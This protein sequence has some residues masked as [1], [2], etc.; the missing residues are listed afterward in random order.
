[1]PSSQPAGGGEGG[2]VHAHTSAGLEGAAAAASLLARASP[3][4]GYSVVCLAAPTVAH[5]NPCLAPTSNNLPHTDT[6]AERLLPRVFCAPEF[7]ARLGDNACAMY[8]DVIPFLGQNP[9][10]GLARA[11]GVAHSCGRFRELPV[12]SQT[13]KWEYQ[14]AFTVFYTSSGLLTARF[15][16]AT[17]A[18]QTQ[19][20]VLLAD[21]LS[22]ARQ[23]WQPAMYTYGGARACMRALSCSVSFSPVPAT[24]LPPGYAPGLGEASGGSTGTGACQRVYRYIYTSPPTADHTHPRRWAA[25][26]RIGLWH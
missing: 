16:A 25:P 21:P 19:V 11:L 10:P 15:C 8:R 7:L 13:G 22:H 24:P 17:A 20:A 5:V 14:I 9:A 1:M 2:W 23:A 6:K 26:A 3:V 4:Q 18:F 12:F